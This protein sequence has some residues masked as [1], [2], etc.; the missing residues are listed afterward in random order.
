MIQSRL[1]IRQ[2]GVNGWHYPTGKRNLITDV[3][4]VAV[5]HATIIKGKSDSGRVDGIIR[6]GVTSV[7]FPGR[8]YYVNP[9]RA[10][11]HVINGFG[12][13]VGL[14]E[15]RETGRIE[16][17]LCITNTL[18]VWTVA[19]SLAKMTLASHPD[20]RSVCPVVGECNDGYL[21]DI[22]GFHV[23]PHHVREAVENAKKDFELGSVGAGTGMR[24]I[25]YKAGVGSASRI[26]H[27]RG[28]DIT[29]GVITVVNTGHIK[30]FR[31]PGI[32]SSI[33][34]SE[35]NNEQPEKGSIV[36]FLATDGMFTSRQLRRLAVRVGHGI[37][38]TGM[39]S[40]HDSGDFVVSFSTCPAPELSREKQPRKTTDQMVVLEE[41]LSPFFEAVVEAS[42]EAFID[43][44][45]TADTMDG[46][47]GHRME[48][49][50]QERLRKFIQEGEEPY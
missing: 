7:T 43:G 2:L 16:T 46:I 11:V 5:G 20:V 33:W 44:V 50:N 3:P 34:L 17:P 22:R 40:A 32:P 26:V 4:G 1:R 27:Y 39:T 21:N 6:T 8:D 48:A 24:G 31:I 28:K 36:L 29:F 35:E 13:T 37:A 15:V 47:K 10:G 49:L 41:D 38:R 30:N 19:E 42:E 14:E 18:S 9:L 23:K 12:K 25:G 45:V